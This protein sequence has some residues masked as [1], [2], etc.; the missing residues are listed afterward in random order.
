AVR[1]EFH[2]DYALTSQNVFL[3]GSPEPTEAVR[4]SGIAK[5]VAGV[6]G[7]EGRAFGKD[8][9]VTGVEPGISQMIRL[10]WTLGSETTLDHLGAAGAVFDKSYAKHHHLAA[11]SPIHLETPGG[12]SLDLKLQG[13]FDPPS[14]GSPFG[15]VTSSAQAFDSVYPTPQNL[16]SFI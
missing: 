8:I 7:G 11:G 13:I 4:K 16:F 10:K 15:S 9:Q 12:K 6:R 1:Q 2:A 5:A 14:G 3:P